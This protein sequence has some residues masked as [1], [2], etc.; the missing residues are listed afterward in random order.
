MQTTFNYAHPDESRPVYY[1]YELEP[2]KPAPV[3]PA[4]KQSAQVRDISGRT[5][6]FNLDT[7]G[8]SCASA[9]CPELD[10]LS[11][12]QVRDNY[13]R[14]CVELVLQAT[15]GEH[16]LAFDHNIRDRS[17][18]ECQSPVRF[19]HND[20]TEQSAPQR[21]YDLLEASDAEQ[22]LK[23]R[24]AFINVW[25]PLSHP[26]LDFPLAICDAQ[27]LHFDDFV[28]TDLKYR[29]RIGEIYSV[30]HAPRH[31]WLYFGGMKPDDIYLLKCFDSADDG[32][33]R[34]TAHSSFKAPDISEDVPTR[35]SI[36]VRTIVFF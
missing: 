35:K 13:Y 33:A 9:P 11:A 19:V 16:A 32:R 3:P 18:T 34:Y 2:G 36:E 27:S 10:W 31:A 12:D 4:D 28:P 23:R 7:N 22:R 20:Y 29:D 21:V 8:F 25:R 26:A 5:S 15:G 24:Y 1:Q 6:E 30:R 14:D 17:N